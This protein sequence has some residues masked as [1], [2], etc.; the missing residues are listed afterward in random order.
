MFVYVCVCAFMITVLRTHILQ[1][2]QAT[3]HSQVNAWL[4]RPIVNS[5]ESPHH[6]LHV[7]HIIIA[8]TVKRPGWLIGVVDMRD[9]YPSGAVQ[10]EHW[11]RPWSDRCQTGGLSLIWLLI[12]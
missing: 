6:A 4:H 5:D 8:N 10:R 1:T 12:G 2:F 9:S 7:W 3:M 11:L